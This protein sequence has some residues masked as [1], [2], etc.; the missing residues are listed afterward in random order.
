VAGYIID[1]C[2]LLP[3]PLESSI[4]S[5]A[6]FLKANQKKCFITS[7]IK[8][9]AFNLIEQSHD[10]VLNHFHSELKPYL[11]SQGIKELTNRDGKIIAKFFSEQKK[12]FKQK[13]HAR[14]SIPNEYINAIESYLADEIHSLPNGKSI[15]VDVFLASAATELAIAKHSLKSPFEGMRCESVAPNEKLKSA[16]ATG[17]VM[18]NSMDITHLASALFYQ[19]GSNRWV[20]FVTNDQN[21]ILNRADEMDEMFLKCNSPQWAADYYSDLTRNKAPL[22]WVQELATFTSRQKPVLEAIDII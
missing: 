19:F 9:E 4:R 7:S 11:D 17:A 18:K 3:Q 13:T 21:E 10:V 16:I 14:S 5:S 1:T 12:V 20:I 6:S 15:P 22:Y 2:V 8:E